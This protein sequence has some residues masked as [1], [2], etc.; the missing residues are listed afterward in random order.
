MSEAD[1]LVWVWP[2]R[3]E[4][5]AEAGPPPPLARPPPGFEVR[6]GGGCSLQKTIPL[7]A[8][9]RAIGSAGLKRAPMRLAQESLRAQPELLLCSAALPH[10]RSP[11]NQLV[12]VCLLATA[13][14][15]GAGA[16]RARGARPAAGESA[17][18]GELLSRRILF[19]QNSMLATECRGTRS[20]GGEPSGG[21]GCVLCM[22]ATCQAEGCML[23][24]NHKQYQPNPTS[25]C[26]ASLQA[27][28]P[29]T[30][31][32]TFAKGWPV[33]G[34]TL[35]SNSGSIA[36]CVAVPLTVQCDM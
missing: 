2:G 22:A 21:V 36:P 10:C 6:L 31:T 1:G 29:F 8:G 34:E 27:H 35:K 15:C 17:G 28:A 12:Y 3:P 4:V 26:G 16:G 7:S 30:H 24:A 18:P 5:H 32:T 20:A 19:N 9:H 25:A 11:A 33:P 23:A 14:A 13:G